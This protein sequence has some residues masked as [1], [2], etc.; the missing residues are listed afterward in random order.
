MQILKKYT[1][2]H[3]ISHSSNFINDIHLKIPLYKKQEKLIH[4]FILYAKNF[5]HEMESKYCIMESINQ[6]KQ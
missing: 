5:L 6:N 4:E 2:Q 1:Y 3:F